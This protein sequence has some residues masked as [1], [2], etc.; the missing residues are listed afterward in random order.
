MGTLLERPLIKKDFQTKFPLIIKAVDTE[1]DAVK[2]LYDQQMSSIHTS[3]GMVDKNMPKVAG[4]LRWSQELTERVQ[5]MMEKFST[6]N[7]G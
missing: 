5:M 3:D 7:H 4:L 1:L 6:L 2:K